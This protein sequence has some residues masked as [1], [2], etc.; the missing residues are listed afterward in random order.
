MHKQAYCR[1]PV[2]AGLLQFRERAHEVVA[3]V[4]FHLAGDAGPSRISVG[5]ERNYAVAF[6]AVPDDPCASTCAL[7]NVVRVLAHGLDVLEHGL[8]EGPAVCRG[9]ER[10]PLP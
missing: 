4:L 7:W 10:L 8:L 6:L 9:R 5:T 1:F 3:R 2:V